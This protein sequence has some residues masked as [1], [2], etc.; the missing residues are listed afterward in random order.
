MS[1]T[2]KSAE[3]KER[4]ISKRN[5]DKVIFGYK[6]ILI[7]MLIF[8]FMLA[9]F[10][11]IKDKKGA[12]EIDKPVYIDQW[13][14]TDSEGN[15][16][17]TGRYHVAEKDYKDYF[18]I[19]ATLPDK[20]KDNS[21]L[22]F[23]TGKNVEVYVNGKLRKDFVEKRDVVLPG[24]SVKRFY[25]LVPLESEDSGGQVRMVR[26][27]T[28]K[29]GQIV[30]RTFVSS[31]AGVYL[32]ILTRHGLPFMLAEV[33]LIFSIVVVIISMVLAFWQKR[34]INMLY[35]ALGISII[36]GWVITNSFV[37]PFVFGHNYIDGILNYMFCLLIPF[38][39]GMYLYVI[40]KR[41]YRKWMFVIMIVSTINAIVWPI[42][43]FTDIF[44][45]YD[46]LPFINVILGS[47]A[48]AAVI[49]IVIDIKRGY[50][51]EYQYTAIGFM[52]FL[53]FGIIEVVDL[54]FLN[55]INEELPMVFGM[56]VFLIF[57]VVQ[58]A[59]DTRKIY[60]EKQRAVDISEAKTRFLASM[61]HE[62]RTPINSVLGMNEMILRENN[63]ETIDEYAQTIKRSGNMLLM[64]VND[65]LDFSK[66]EAGKIEIAHAE[67]NFETVV[68]D[69]ISLSD[70]KASEKG[71]SLKYEIQ[72][73]VPVGQVGDEFRVRQ[74]LVNLL[75]NA[76]KYTDRGSVS[77]NI[78]GR[79]TDEGYELHISVADTGRGIK[80]ED[81][82]GLFDAF[83]RADI[84]TNVNIEGTGLGLAIVKSIIDSMSGSI[85]VESE[86]GVGS[87]FKIVLPVEVYDRT[88]V[89]KNIMKEVK[90]QKEE[91]DESYFYAPEANILAVD[92]NRSNLNIVRLLLKRTGIIPDLCTGGKEAVEL[93]KRKRYDLI[94]MDHMMP[95]PNGIETLKIIRDDK[96]SLN[97][98]T[99][100]I[101]LTANAVAGS[102]NMYMK[103][104]FADYIVKPIDYRVLEGVVKKY[105]PEEK[106]V[107]TGIK[108]KSNSRS[109]SDLDYKSR[110]SA[111]E[112]FDYDTAINYCAGDEAFLKEIMG[113]VY[114]ECDERI[115]RMRG[116]IQ[117]KDFASYR[118]EAHSIKGS[119]ATIGFGA[120]SERAKKHEFAARDGEY[121]FIL[122]DF[123][124]FVE[125]YTSICQKIKSASE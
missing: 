53:F 107:D 10:Y 93:C 43:H 91:K 33:L 36:C 90:R 92:D 21:V 51:R 111:I 38:G 39:L 40:Q 120:F 78:G 61:S 52:G 16:F 9:V 25:M 98:D 106:I 99:T 17:T 4:V 48:V 87:E 116:N 6:I 114:G 27:G 30:P 46:A 67:Y 105:L 42:L 115:D 15:S 102:R 3:K 2:H 13:T 97:H 58:Q 121:D 23:Q 56:T 109:L 50:A 12:M 101:V 28:S 110:I 84:N 24:G 75:N 85:T 68:S 22:C 74:I 79:Y 57:M 60:F 20:I 41:R 65:V 100:I 49:I 5:T 96:E 82:Q 117:K 94:F 18:T 81:R 95:S 122:E 54:L 63:D 103:A 32:Y 86:Y 35:G 72:D 45:F 112:G 26:E 80:E 89:V 55:P 70:E 123:D 125:E 37:F 11:A 62:I 119:M 83:S 118:I 108:E 59:Y 66:I 31:M 64:L 29:K 7:L 76:V 44:H 19:E 14:V 71:L 88:P 1:D 77:L 104:G 34:E 69:V 73:D 124:S 8:I 47:M 113:D